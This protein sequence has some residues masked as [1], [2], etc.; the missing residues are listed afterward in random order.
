MEAHRSLTNK[1]AVKH[2][3]KMEVSQFDVPPLAG[4]N[5]QSGKTQRDLTAL[6]YCINTDQ[7]LAVVR[8]KYD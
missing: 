8:T 7:A 3:I 2:R 1:C 5:R 6:L 4:E